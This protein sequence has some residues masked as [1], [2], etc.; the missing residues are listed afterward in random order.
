MRLA[1]IR[2][3]GT[4]RAV[5]IDGDTVT[6]LG[7]PDVRAVLEQPDWQSLCT[8]ASGETWSTVDVKYET[9]VT[10]PSKVFCV[11]LNY[12]NHIEEMGHDHPEY[13]TLFMKFADA[14]TGANDPI[15]LPAESTQVDWE[16]ELTI[17]IGREIRYAGR[18]EAE[19]AIAGFTIMNDTSMRDWQRRT[20]QWL[21][22][23]NWDRATPV[24]PVMVTPDELPGGVSPEVEIWSRVDDQTMQSDNTRQLLFKPAELVEYVSTMIRLRPGDMIATGTPSGVGHARTPAVYLQSGQTITC[25]IDGIGEVSNLVV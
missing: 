6:D 17:V 18:S 11:G 3:H 16:A 14:L 15:A 12:Q 8:A 24:G 23:K 25:G 19:Q 2:V 10:H 21:Q 22:G 1:T 7:V 5:R 20:T 13:P 4:T 9:L